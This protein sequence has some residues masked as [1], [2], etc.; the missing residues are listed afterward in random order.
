MCERAVRRRAGG[1]S[2]LPHEQP[3]LSLSQYWRRVILRRVAVSGRTAR[4]PLRGGLASWPR[5]PYHGLKGRCRDHGF[6]H[7]D[8][9]MATTPLERG[10]V[11]RTCSRD[12]SMYSTHGRWLLRVTAA[13][14][15]LGTFEGADSEL[16]VKTGR[17]AN[18]FTSSYKVHMATR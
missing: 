13:A 7:S 5:G 11:L 1:P 12:G 17:S 16:R 9:A 3:K 10:E 4:R 14:H 8:S 6:Y 18:S 15:E 2:H